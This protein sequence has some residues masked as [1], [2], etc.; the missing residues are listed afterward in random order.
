VGSRLFE[1]VHKVSALLSI[2]RDKKKDGLRL[3]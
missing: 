2:T 3:D 1:V